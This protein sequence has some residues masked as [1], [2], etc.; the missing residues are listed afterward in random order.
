MTSQCSVCGSETRA[1]AYV[2]Q[3]FAFL[4][5]QDRDIFKELKIL[6]CENCGFGFAQPFLN[7][8]ALADFYR[9][10]YGAEGS[11]HYELCESGSFAWR[12]TINPRFIAQLLLAGQYLD[13]SKVRKY[14]D[15]GANVG[16]AFITFKRMGYNAEYF[17]LEQGEGLS[18]Y[19]EKAG[20]R[21][22]TARDRYLSLGSEYENSFDLI[23]LSHV[24]EHFNADQLLGILANLRRYLTDDGVLVCEVPNDD[25]RLCRI[26][27]R[28]AA[29]HLSFFSITSLASLF[30]K[31]GLK[32]KYINTV[33][34]GLDKG[35]GLSELKV[36]QA[37]WLK[38]RLK[39]I[40]FIHYIRKVLPYF[41]KYLADQAGEIMRSPDL[42]YGGE[43]AN[44]RLCAGKN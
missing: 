33:G 12:R 10:D 6:T 38:R 31:A 44:I 18:S 2:N 11:P 29:P 9:V 19:L 42:A 40:R 20:A 36:K 1:I 15:V 43:R 5:K 27:R 3:H 17:A 8:Q 35:E 25:C 4:K 30:E 26:D 37:N 14:L 16:A 23:T 41:K 24:L 22:L 21:V 13:L 7:D 32:I 34:L 39:K 28:N